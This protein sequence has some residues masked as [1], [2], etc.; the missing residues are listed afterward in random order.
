[1]IP[2]LPKR[3]AGDRP[4]IP[5]PDRRIRPEAIPQLA[6]L[7]RANASLTK[8]RDQLLHGCSYDAVRGA[9]LRCAASDEFTQALADAFPA[10]LKATVENF[11]EVW[12]NQDRRVPSREK[13]RSLRQLVVDFDHL[14]TTVGALREA[15]TTP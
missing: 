5:I 11:L 8:I 4:F 3:V 15:R 7:L 14:A 10:A 6:G 12:R 13:F 9:V 1:M 2:P